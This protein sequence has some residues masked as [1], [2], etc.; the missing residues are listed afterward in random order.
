V[1]LLG[2]ARDLEHAGGSRRLT[3]PYGGKAGL[4]VPGRAKMADTKQRMEMNDASIFDDMSNG[5]EV[6]VDDVPL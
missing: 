5:L 4:E 3:G 1:S 2:H 6:R